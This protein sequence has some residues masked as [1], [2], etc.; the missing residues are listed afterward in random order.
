VYGVWNHIKNSGEFPD[1]KNLTLEWVGTVP[2]KRESRRFEGD[3]MLTQ[4]DIIQQ[5]QHSDAISFGGW[6]ID[7][8][9]ADGVYSEKP[10]CMQWHS[11]GLYQI[12]YRCLYSRNIENLFLAG[13][14]ISA[15]HIA[16]GSTRVMATCGHNAQAVGMA[17]SLCK[18]LGVMPRTLAETD[19]VDKLQRDLLRTGHY[20][21]GRRLEDSND[22]V[23]S[24]EI[25]SS[26]RLLLD[27]LE[28]NGPWLR[29]N[30]SWGMLLPVAAGRVP[31][32]RLQVRCE[33]P[34]KLHCELRACSRLGSY[35]PD[36]V[37][38]EQIV[39]IP[40][41]S[42]VV[43]HPHMAARMVKAPQSA[44]AVAATEHPSQ[45]K[46]HDGP[47]RN[48]KGNGSL[49]DDL[50]QG[51]SPFFTLV[52]ES[53]SGDSINQAPSWIEIQFNRQ[54]PE[55]QYVF[56]CLQTNPIVSVRC[57]EQRVTG[58]LSVTNRTHKRV[59]VSAIQTPPPDSGIDTF[60]YWRPL[61]RP[62]GHN[63]A[64]ELDPPLDL[65]GPEQVT[66]GI[67]RP[68]L[69]PNAWVAALDD[70][71]PTLNFN[72]SLPQTIGRVELS[73]DTDFDHPM[74]SVLMGHPEREMPYCVRRFRIFDDQGRELAH[75]EDNYQ[76]RR[77]IRFQNPIT[78]T[79]LHIE[80][81]SPSA[82]IPAALFEVRCYSE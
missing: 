22:L 44:L 20:I 48:G 16:F 15:T 73:F 10:G 39:D 59:S 11:K 3:Y 76:T 5:R 81:E 61:R 8:H 1:A 30:E 55:A 40:S 13:R 74:E 37:M 9:P 79:R 31:G 4:Q 52:D 42:N 70:P 56:I 7:L 54:M 47:H 71:R 32:I 23:Q 75:V 66:N 18:S 51:P 14:V 82:Q 25:T 50:Y 2:G 19:K 72:W 27:R 58:I 17:A 64:M 49:N 12:P 53:A 41:A 80:L 34:T 6:A 28:P 43:P 29:L 26:S 68:T 67:G 65:F 63:L 46:T 38:A 57:S 78:T 35:T 60:E 69:S 36:V 77:S 62:G 24:A 21:P 33:Q 45:G